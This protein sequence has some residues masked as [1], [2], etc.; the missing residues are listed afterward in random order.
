MSTPKISRLTL[1][2]LSISKATRFQDE[3]VRIRKKTNITSEW[4]YHRLKKLLLPG[5]FIACETCG[6]ATLFEGITIDHKIPRSYHKKYKGNIHDTHN[7][8]FVCSSC[9]SMKGVKTLEEFLEFLFK[10]NDE[11]VTL[12]KHSTEIVAPLYPNI[13]LGLKIF[14]NTA[15]IKKPRK[16]K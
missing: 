6:M 5:N 10:R 2:G 15:V 4:I 3:L 9:N 16:I 11:I 12:Q 14:G 13:G 1:H 7:L 8:E